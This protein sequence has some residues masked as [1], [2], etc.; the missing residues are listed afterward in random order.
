M[1]SS[2][3]LLILVAVVVGIAAAVYLPGLL[4]RMRAE[5][6]ARREQLAVEARERYDFLQ[7]SLA[8][9]FGTEYLADSEVD[10][11]RAA[12]A[13]ALALA[14]D[15][16]FA[17]HLPEPQATQA[18]V[19]CEQ[20][21]S[22][23]AS[24]QVHND[25][26][27]AGRL[28]E[29]RAALDAVEKYPL[30]ERQR[31]AIVTNQDSNL[32]VAGAGTG[33]TST[34]VG[35]VDYLIRRRLAAPQEILVLAFARKAS[36]ELK[37]R[38]VRLGG[39]EGVHVS[40]F[41]ALGLGIISEVEGKRPTLSPLAE[42]DRALKRFI[43]DR[44][45]EM[46]AEPEC[47]RLLVDFFSTLLDEEQP[48]DDAE[49]GDEYIR[50][51]QGQGLYALNGQKM[52][53]RQEV[54]IANWLTLN[55]VA[56]AYERPYP[57]NT[58]TPWH[59]QYK[60]DFYLPEHDLY[61]EHFGIDRKGNT[62]P[63]VNKAK[64]HE[65]MVWKRALHRQH[66]TALLETFSYFAQEG[67]LVRR[68][69]ELLRGRGVEP[70]PLG[71]EEI[72]AIASEANRPFSLFVDLIAQF[73]SV[74]KGNGGTPEA[75][76]RKAATERDLVFLR[77][78]RR[79]LDPYTAELEGSGEIDFNDMIGRA[80]DYVREGRC[81]R[82]Y[83]Y[84]VVDEFQDI[85]ENRLG[86]LQDLRAQV[87]HGRLFAVGDD[88]QAI[89]RF[90]GSDVG[91]ITH[92]GERVGATARVDLD[93]TFRYPQELLD[94]SSRFVMAN[95]GQLRKTLRSHHGERGILPACVVFTGGQRDGAD[96]RAPF[97]VA[98]RDILARKGAG[99]ATLFVLG[100][101]R[102]S[103]PDCFDDLQ[104][105]LRRAGIDAEYHTAHASKGKEADYVIVVGLEAGEYGFPANVADD[106]VMRMVLSAPEDYPYAEERRL[107]YVAITRARERV[108]LIAPQDKPSP[109]IQA[110]IL[111]GELQEYAETIGEVSERHRCPNCDGKTIRRRQGQFGDFWA[112]T[113]F[114]LCHGRLDAC[115]QCPDGGLALVE[116]G[117]K[118][119]I[120]RCTICA[121][122]AER[123]P[124]CQ[125]GH[126]RERTGPRGQFLA[127]SRWDR[128]A[129]CT[130]TRSLPRLAPS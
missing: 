2:T 81:R 55:G 18:R 47:H 89:Y 33:K 7:R 48:G 83:R 91:I 45:R 25:R 4:G 105:E 6:A 92:L 111:E 30:T 87:P 100:R 17:H 84:I 43:R 44:V 128:G 114:P 124:R 39:H 61:L 88:W 67:G 52:K 82:G 101:Y 42:D 15:D 38:V 19:W 98:C 36:E 129:G 12:N 96:P 121:R 8:T 116:D 35:K 1:T 49:T 34:I 5:R 72:R 3:L 122:E 16:G 79:V 113:N 66:G 56:W 13:P 23:P 9:L 104:E 106:P 90:T 109:F 102:F 40:T 54:Q 108:Y 93:T 57:V 71:E 24:V 125:G 11:W 21:R 14:A 10:A 130:Y 76:A 95:S 60:P 74:Y 63:Q 65:A 26:F 22:L 77:L 41:H 118:P 32:I 103:R 20:L 51:Q 127:C 112:C 62:A 37:E 50:A 117:F 75:A 31:I 46:L 80:R 120:Y 58:A 70:R 69:E 94:F 68:L 29:E 97:E 53:S 73:L 99:R 126:L 64:Y 110:D 123:C 59:R 107:F 119:P 86:L 27:V 85:S 28:L 115:K 78:F